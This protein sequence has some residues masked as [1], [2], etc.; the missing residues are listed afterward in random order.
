MKIQR[1][2]FKDIEEI[3]RININKNFKQNFQGSSPAPFIGRFGYPNINIGFLSPQ[4]SGDTSYYDS[5]KEWNTSNASIEKI[6]GLRYRLVNSRTKGNVKKLTGK[7]LDLV[8]EVGMT[9]N[10][11]EMEV[12]LKKPPK[13]NFKQEKEVIPFGPASE[14][15]K[16]RATENAKVDSRVEK[17]VY[18]TDLKSAQGIISLYKK[19]FEE[20]FL[21]KLLSV[22][23]TGLKKNRK[24]VPTRWSITAVDDTVGKQLIKEIKDYSP[25]DFKTYFG[26]GWGNYYLILFFPKVWSFELF[27][28]Y[29][30]KTVNPWS[31]QGFVYST[32]YENYEGRKNYA[33][34]CAGGYYACRLGILEKL[35]SLKRQ[36][37]VLALRF[38]TSKYNIPLGVWT[39]RESTR[40]SLIENPITFASQELMLRY[41]KLFIQRKLSFDISLL[42]K[43]SKLL[44]EK[45]AQK[46]L[47]EFAS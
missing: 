36:G 2:K 23:N 46:K 5:P 25:G 3:S 33:Q 47:N 24:L 40:K 26:G 7:L 13:L 4:I 45:D 17:V 35:K 39:C 11:I 30:N 41:A 29:M 32:D 27:E 31:M 38:I 18:D 44:N 21:N 34:E 28:T 8:K 12:S 43:E 22:G 9:K 42:L 1:V 20:T 16:A 6:A 14:I 19:G 15:L 37:S 10:S